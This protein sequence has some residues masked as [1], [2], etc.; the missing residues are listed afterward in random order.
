MSSSTHHLTMECIPRIPEDVSQF[1]I[2]EAKVDHKEHGNNDNEEHGLGRWSLIHWLFSRYWPDARDHDFLDN[3]PINNLH[4][5]PL[6]YP[7]LVDSPICPSEAE[8]AQLLARSLD[9]H[10]HNRVFQV[11]SGTQSD[12]SGLG[13]CILHHLAF[14]QTRAHWVM[15]GWAAK[16]C[17]SC[18][19][20][21]P[22]SQSSYRWGHL[23]VIINYR[24]LITPSFT[25]GIIL[26]LAIIQHFQNKLWYTPSWPMLLASGC[27]TPHF[28][29]LLSGKMWQ[30]VTFKA[31]SIH[32]NGAVQQIPNSN[33]GV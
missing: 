29:L 3:T 23:L 27:V 26:S 22:L 8:A 15:F 9:L 12:V 14:Q 4:S 7:L 11:N 10:Y 18:I 13:P 32:H 16:V 6:C 21:L 20:P 17:I 31:H 33:L 24:R 25:I 28:N 30:P 5:V 19:H 2:Q 1:F